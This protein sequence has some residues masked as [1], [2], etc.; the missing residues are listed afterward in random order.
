MFIAEWLI[1]GILIAE[2][3]YDKRLNE[4][5]RSLKK[6]TQ[7]RFEFSELNQGEMR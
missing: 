5:V 2:Y 6:R 4:H 7:K 3:L 1:V